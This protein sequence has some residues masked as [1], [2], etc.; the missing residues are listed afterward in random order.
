V[1]SGE[2]RR[3]DPCRRVVRSVCARQSRVHTVISVKRTRVQVKHTTCIEISLRFSNPFRPWA[4]PVPYLPT[5]TV[6]RDS[7]LVVYDFSFDLEHASDLYGVPLRLLL[8]WK[9]GLLT[10]R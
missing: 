6:L 5:T 10:G 3:V 2:V 9:R 4:E 7:E 1:G 8:C